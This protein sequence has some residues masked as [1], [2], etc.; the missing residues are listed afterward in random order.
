MGPEFK[1]Q[2]HKKKKNKKKKKEKIGWSGEGREYW[3][4]TSGT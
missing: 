4:C 1:H 2:Y 3:E